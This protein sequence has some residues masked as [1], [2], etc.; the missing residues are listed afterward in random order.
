LNKNNGI[1]PGRGGDDFPHDVKGETGAEHRAIAID[2]E[3]YGKYL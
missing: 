3:V 2:K 1:E